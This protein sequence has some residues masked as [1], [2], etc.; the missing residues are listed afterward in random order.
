MIETDRWLA[1]YGA[2]HRNITHPLVYWL[3]VPITVLG[4]VGLL[5]ALPIPAEFLAISPIFNWGTAF[6][7]AAVVYYFIISL[8]LAFG[9]LPFVVAV[10]AFHLWLQLSPFSS[11]RASLG[12]VSGGLLG[13]YLGHYRGD[14]LR[15][16]ARDIQ[17]MM[18]API[19]LLSR[20]YRRLGIPQ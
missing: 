16:V 6:L 12:M 11:L 8:P 20:L 15:A 4:T 10:V 3:S 5:W 1:D 7:L 17:L 2:S 13:L 18:I 9:M 19:W 14:G